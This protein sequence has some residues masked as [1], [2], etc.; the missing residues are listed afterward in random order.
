L[1]T[2]VIPLSSGN[3]AASPSDGAFSSSHLANQ[4]A[5]NSTFTLVYAFFSRYKMEKDP[6]KFYGRMDPREMLSRVRKSSGIAEKD[7]TDPSI[8]LLH[9]QQSSYPRLRPLNLVIIIEESLG[10]EYV[11]CLGGIPLTP[12]LDELSKEGVLFMNLYSTGTRTIRAIEAI[13]SGFLPT[14]GESVVR[15]G[16]AQKDF[17]TIADLLLRN[18][19]HTEFVYGGES[20]FDNMRGF[21]LGNGFQKVYEQDNYDNPV[22]KGTLGVSDEDLF[23]KANTIFRAHG[24]RPFFGLILTTSNHIPFEFPDGRIALYESPKNTR[25]NAVKYA[26]YALGNF[27]KFAKKEAYYK[28]TL[29]LVIADHST[30]LK[31]MELIPIK[32]FHIPGLIIG[33]GIR[34]EK[35]YKLASQIDMPPTLLDLMGL[36]TKHPLIGRPLL[37]LPGNVP[38]RAVMQYSS[39]NAFMVEK[40]LIVQRP[41]LP[42]I[43]YTHKNGKVEGTKSKFNPDLY[44]DALAH[45]LLPWY[46]YKNRLH[47][48]PKENS[49]GSIT[50]PSLP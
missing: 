7:F 23:S 24:D 8:P 32:K 6:G 49:Y 19:Y 34:S 14:L 4:L 25:Y 12:N 35:Y 41:G 28:N 16:L 1:L 10:A 50:Y 33:P 39:T 22:F 40:Q 20:R 45:S 48:I 31:G 38:G 2:I 18:G 5:L 11:G 26:D 44:R 43:E 13:I 46:L 3:L 15:L 21:F 36:S 47:H 30:R 37:T 17:F 42:P 29:F 9:H 27:F